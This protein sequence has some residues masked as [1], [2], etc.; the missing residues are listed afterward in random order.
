MSGQLGIGGQV[1]QHRF[2]VQV[3]VRDVYGQDPVLGQAVE[4]QG[5][6]LAGEQVYGNGVGAEGVDQQQ[7]EALGSVLGQREPGIAQHDLD[8]RPAVFPAVAEV[9]EQLRV[10]GDAH[11]RRID[12]VEGDPLA[13]PPVG[14]DGAGPQ[15]DHADL[16]G[17]A[18]RVQGVEDLAHR[19]RAVVIGPRLAA[20]LEVEALYAVAGRAVQELVVLVDQDAV[21]VARPVLDP[22]HAE[23]APLGNQGAELLAG[24]DE[25]DDQ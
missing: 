22:Q 6:R 13:R 16:A 8:L 1:P 19:P 9:S 25:A 18:E 5:Q 2:Q 11:H 10:L 23:E 14:G 21:L 15:P 17:R 3:A 20:L 4:V 7:V 24:I 12:F